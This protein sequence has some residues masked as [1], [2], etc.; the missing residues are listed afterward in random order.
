MSIVIESKPT[1]PEQRIE[2]QRRQQ[3]NVGP[4]ERAASTAIG[5]ALV[6][7]GLAGRRHVV[8]L[9]AGS[10]LLYRGIS[11]NCGLYRALGIDR[12]QCD[13][14]DQAAVEARHAIHVD[15]AIIINRPPGMIYDFWKQFDQLPQ[16]IDHLVSVT[17]VDDQKSHWIAQGPLNSQFEWDA[18]V[19]EDRHGELL[20]WRSLP[21]S[22]VS[23]AGTLRLG[24]LPHNRG[25]SVRLITD[26]EP[27]GGR[28][29][30]QIASWFGTDVEAELF[31]GLRRMKQILE[32]GERPTIEGQ[33]LGACL[34]STTERS[35]P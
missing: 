13:Q 31:E 6:V 1:L 7:A 20:A 15:R 27:P 33:P 19:F 18:E 16:L 12:C 8:P 17:Q 11:G 28:I 29:T 22:E 25:T 23:V 35:E 3:P 10:A 30:A 4:L 5:A 21:D 14:Q 34:A 26:Y 32:S 24:V 9:A 2:P